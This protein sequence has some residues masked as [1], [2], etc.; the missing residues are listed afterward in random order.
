[1]K[2]IITENKLDKVALTWLNNNFG[3]LTPVV[4]DNKTYYVNKDGKLIFYYSQDKKNDLV[5]I[6]YGE[7]WLFL[8]SI[9]GMNGLQIQGL[10]RHWLEETYNLKGLIPQYDRLGLQ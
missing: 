1:M 4:K 8:K 3:D 6:N 7:I 10:T 5:Y 2:Y 9:F